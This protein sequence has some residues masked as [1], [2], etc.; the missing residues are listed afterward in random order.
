MSVTFNFLG[1]YDVLKIECIRFLD[2][3]DQAR[4]EIAIPR[5]AKLSKYLL[6]TSKELQKFCEK[7]E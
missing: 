5:L 2:I 1:L 3:E 7:P 4:L 6:L